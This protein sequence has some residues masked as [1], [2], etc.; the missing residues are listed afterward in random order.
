[1]LAAEQV[2]CLHGKATEH[3]VSG[4]DDVP[5]T[6]HVSGLRGIRRHR[7]SSS[8]R[9]CCW[10]GV[11]RAK[12]RVVLGGQLRP[13]DHFSPHTDAQREM[14]RRR[15]RLPARARQG[16]KA[17]AS[18]ERIGQPVH[19]PG[20]VGPRDDQGGAIR[21]VPSCA[22]FASTRR[23]SRRSQITRADGCPGP[24]CTPAHS[25]RPRT[26]DTRSAGKRRQQPVQV[27]P[28]LAA[29]LLVLPRLEQSHHR[30]AD[31]AREGVAAERAAVLTRTDH[32]HDVPVRDD[33][34]TPARAHHRVPCRAR[35]RPARPIRDRT[36][37]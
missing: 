21:I 19:R 15:R 5:G 28:Q 18:A 24:N 25:P 11:P 1:M 23:A 27:L 20:E 13:G 7:T 4:V 16:Q 14:T 34:P 8:V 29:A 36:R 9:F 31:R 22:S 2:G 12:A 32:P 3:H 33:P 30:A 26:S 37:T 17:L 10:P 6:G 35:R